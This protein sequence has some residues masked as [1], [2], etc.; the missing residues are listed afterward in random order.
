M[1]MKS[2]N[3]RITHYYHQLQTFAP[4]KRGK[5]IQQNLLLKI[6]L[7]ILRVTKKETTLN[8][9]HLVTHLYLL[10]LKLE[11]CLVTDV[12]ELKT[13]SKILRVKQQQQNIL[14][15]FSKGHQKMTTFNVL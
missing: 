14:E 4:T 3:I 6:Y 1:N 12:A 7:N 2:L 15:F 5:I 10:R 8:H 9:F 11:S 13:K